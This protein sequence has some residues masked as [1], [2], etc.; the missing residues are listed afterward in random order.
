MLAPGMPRRC[1]RDAWSPKSEQNIV[2]FSVSFLRRGVDIS[3]PENKW[4]ELVLDLKTSKVLSSHV[5]LKIHRT[6]DYATFKLVLCVVVFVLNVSGLSFLET[7]IRLK[8]LELL[9]IW[10]KDLGI[11]VLISRYYELWAQ[12]HLEKRSC[13]CTILRM[14]Q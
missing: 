4:V 12:I 3:V 8:T 1:P 11:I 10:S 9:F 2:L 5:F 6:V 14:S 7:H 13:E